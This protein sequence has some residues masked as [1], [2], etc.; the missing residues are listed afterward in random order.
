M[1]S[2]AKYYQVVPRNSLA[3]RLVIRARDPHLR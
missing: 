1:S 3:E 2:D